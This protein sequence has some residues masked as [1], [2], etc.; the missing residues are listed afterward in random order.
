MRLKWFV[1]IIFVL[2]GGCKD[3][4]NTPLEGSDDDLSR[5]V[6]EGSW[7]AE[8]TKAHLE[9]KKADKPGWYSFSLKEPE[10]LIEGK[11]MVAGF[12]R[13][14]ALSI[15]MSSLRI[16]GEPL[17]RE[18][19]QAY[20]LVGAYFNDEELRIAPANMEKFERNFSDYFFATPIETASLCVK[21][22]ASCKTTFASGNILFSKNRRK[23]QEDFVKHFRTV[24]PRRDSV[25]FVPAT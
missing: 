1:C 5:Y 15:E 4:L 6:I 10:K 3:L 23:F 25:V 12:K 9:L 7:F 18:D 21:T 2:L 22:S 16:N 17:T 11:V 19:K 14:F 20:F 13:K 24:F 8:A